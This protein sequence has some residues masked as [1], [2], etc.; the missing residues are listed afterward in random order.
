MAL[1]YTDNGRNLKRALELAHAEFDV[2]NDVYSWDALSWVLYKNRQ[3][4]EAAKASEKA[5]A[6]HT[7]EPGFYFHAGIIAEANGDKSRAKTLLAKA[8]ALNP[9][10]DPRNAPIAKAALERLG[11]E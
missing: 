10:F 1:I 5:L 7:P 8:L 9:E 2:R 6:Q 11:R 4:A 3:F